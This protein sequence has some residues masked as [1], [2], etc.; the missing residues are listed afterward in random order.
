M[1]IRPMSDI[2][3]EFD[4]LAPW[5]MPK[6][7]GE[8]EMV[9]V[10]AGDITANHNRW[11]DN[12]AQDRYSPWIKDVCARHKHVI[13]IKGN[14][15]DYEGRMDATEDHWKAMSKHIENLH[16][17]HRDVVVLD[18]VRFIGCTL[19]TDL[20]PTQVLGSDMNDF[21]TIWVP[22]D[23]MERRGFTVPDW[24]M[25]HEAC[26][27]FLDTEIGKDFDGE[28]V[29]VTHHAPSFQSIH[30]KFAGKSFNVFY[31]SNLEKYMWYNPIKYWIHGHVHDSLD[32]EVGDDL[33]STRV[34][35]N[36]RG[37]FGHDENRDF[38]PRL[39]IEV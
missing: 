16:F 37:Y 31:A 26:R 6:I 20:P 1:I 19:W 24:R 29:V 13:Y 8:S 33:Q 23:L 12:P 3:L 2:H 39:T 10:L 4:G 5:Y 35:C 27:Y 21:D 34:I 36:P 22:D 17:L 25:E 14:H 38:N 9:L 28:T 18:G 11:K 30:S 7:E 15:E 32:Y